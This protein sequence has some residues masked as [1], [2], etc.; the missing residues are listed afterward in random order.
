MS[1]GAMGCSGAVGCGC[2]SGATGSGVTG[3]GT[4]RSRPWLASSLV[5]TAVSLPM[6]A[7]SAAL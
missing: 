5:I 2:G 7:L 6:L 3:R 4:Y 1:S